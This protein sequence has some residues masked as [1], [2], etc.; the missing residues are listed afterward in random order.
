MDSNFIE[1]SS[2]QQALSISIRSAVIDQRSLIL[3]VGRDDYY[4]SLHTMPIEEVCTIIVQ[5]HSAITHCWIKF[6]LHACRMMIL[7]IGRLL[8]TVLVSTSSFLGKD[9]ER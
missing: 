4:S 2:N 9:S 1:K 6:I 7:H 5:A 8:M 3:T